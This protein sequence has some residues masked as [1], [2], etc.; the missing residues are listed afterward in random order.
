MN[1]DRTFRVSRRASPRSAHRALLAIL[2]A[3]GSIPAADAQSTPPTSGVP[4]MRCVTH[5]QHGVRCDT[6]PTGR[7]IVRSPVDRYDAARVA[8]L[9][10]PRQPAVPQ[11]PGAEPLPLTSESAP[12]PTVPP[13]GDPSS[14]VGDI[15]AGTNRLDYR[16]GMV[17]TTFAWRTSQTA[18]EVDSVI[19]DGYRV[20][21]V[22]VVSLSPL[23]FA[24]IY[25]RNAGAYQRDS[26]W[27]ADITST[28]LLDQINNHG[29][30]VTRLSPR[31]VGVATRFTAVMEKNTDGRDGALYWDGGF[32]AQMQAFADDN[33]RP[34]DVESYATENGI[35]FAA[36]GI[37]N[38]GSDHRPWSTGVALSG[39]SVEFM[40]GLLDFTRAVDLERVDGRWNV[41]FTGSTFNTIEHGLNHWTHVDVPVSQVLHLVRRHGGR[42]ITAQ[43]SGSVIHDGVSQA[44]YTLTLVENGTPTTGTPRAGFH[45]ID[46]AMVESLKR[47]SIPG[48]AIAIAKNGRLVY[49]RG[50]GYAD[51]E[52][53]VPAS[54]E[55]MFRMGSI[56]K[57]MTG[58]SV[59]KLIEQGAE[60]WNGQPLSLNTRAFDD[61]I[62]PYFESP[63]YV[64]LADIRLGHLLT[65]T[66]GWYEQHESYG[67]PVQ[68]FAGSL[69]LNNTLR[70][71]AGLDIQHTPDCDEIVPYY[72]PR[73]LDASPGS[74]VFYSGLGIC[75]A[76]VV[77]Q[78]LSGKHYAT[79][80]RDEFID[81]LGLNLGQDRFGYSS[82]YL[83]QKKPTEA[84]Y[85][86]SF[87]AAKI[88]PRL[89]EMAVDFEADGT[90]VFDGLVDSPYGGMPMRS[91]WAA[92]SWAASP[93]AMMRLATALDRSRRPYAQSQASLD[94]AFQSVA[95]T[96]NGSW[97]KTG[98]STNGK[99]IWHGGATHGAFAHFQIHGPDDGAQSGLKFVMFFNASENGYYGSSVDRVRSA[100]AAAKD[101]INA[102]N[103]DLFPE[104]GFVEPD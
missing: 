64:H 33:F 61:V 93:V 16:F 27:F 53:D 104:Y 37:R 95:G 20:H 4:T 6:L 47:G 90:P 39:D 42:L 65:H 60:L 84:R 22:E 62:F 80:F 5:P 91:I 57:T 48:G 36:V 87:G 13:N 44:A 89:I 31:R 78:A 73:A 92:G 12:P 72:F 14:G 9:R 59:M 99:R 86:D 70:I 69:P 94:A 29:Y 32:D 43:R 30:R 58:L 45:G 23:R 66:G 15:S 26:R 98:F 67:L 96:E 41:I 7:L 8:A 56:S 25:V 83:A 74:N 71:A 21:D 19:A 35:R 54:P 68:G 79:H 50:Y 18:S 52:A 97:G 3:V 38:E 1:A 28:Q 76:A 77:V 2:V 100:I 40:S 81:P 103:W 11:V 34:V 85:Y 17:D 10:P 55:T 63:T 102:S 88:Q 49:A 51:I 24:V 101:A 46:R 75:A 82:D